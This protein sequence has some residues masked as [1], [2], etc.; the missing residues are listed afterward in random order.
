MCCF[1]ALI[2]QKRRDDDIE[3][4][5]LTTLGTRAYELLNRLFTTNKIQ[6]LKYKQAQKASNLKGKLVLGG[7]FFFFNVS[8]ITV[9]TSLEY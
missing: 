5:W 4:D 7:D 9:L 3:S 1:S 8:L 6:F 2:K